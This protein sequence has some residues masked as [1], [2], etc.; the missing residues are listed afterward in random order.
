MTKALK[1]SKSIARKKQNWGAGPRNLCIFWV[2]NGKALGSK[3]FFGRRKKNMSE[4]SEIKNK[5]ER[6]IMKRNKK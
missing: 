2:A 3:L 5:K 1:I 6:K 4:K